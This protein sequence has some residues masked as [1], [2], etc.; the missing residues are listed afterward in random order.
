AGRNRRGN[1]RAAADGV[2]ARHAAEANGRA[3]VNSGHRRS[4]ERRLVADFQRELINAVGVAARQRG[5]DIAAA[6]AIVVVLHRR[7]RVVVAE[8][9]DDAIAGLQHDVLDRAEAKVAGQ[10]TAQARRRADDRWSRTVAPHIDRTAGRRGQEQ[11]VAV[12]RV[13]R[14]WIAA[15]DLNIQ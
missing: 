13:G 15:V 11:D 9:V 8:D 1:V 2:D 5:I 3:D 7:R 4:T 10:R 14:Q 6:D 12:W